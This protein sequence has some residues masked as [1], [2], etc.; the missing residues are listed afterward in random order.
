MPDSEQEKK[1]T[2]KAPEPVTDKRSVLYEFVRRIAIV[3]FHTLMP[4]KCHNPERLRADPPYVLISNHQHALDPVAIAIHIPKHQVCFL[5]KKEIGKNKTVN[6]IMTNAHVIFVN[7]HE[8]DM[9]AMRNCMKAVRMKKILVIFPE[10]TRHH[11]GQMEQI[12]NG[13][14]LIAMRTKAPIIPVYIDRK[15]SFFRRT[16]LYVGEPI[17]SEDLIA[18]GINAET[19]EEMNERF[20]ETFRKMIRETSAGADKKA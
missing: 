12:E 6:R 2:K 11:E 1:E 19:C 9:T 10:G 5:A 4:V 14:S 15:L 17:P 8:T 7:R 16:H 3:I 18:K 13:A 20:R